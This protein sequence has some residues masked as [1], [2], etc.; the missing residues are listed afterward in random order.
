MIVRGCEIRYVRVMRAVRNL[1]LSLVVLAFAG[2]G[3]APRA[4]A[5]FLTYHMN[6]GLIGDAAPSNLGSIANG[7]A[8]ATD[9]AAITFL[10]G[11]SCVNAACGANTV[12]L[13]ID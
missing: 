9:Y 12:Q 11:A 7:F 6:T 13:I 4:H 8:L 1:L 5:A 2:F 10:D 3:L